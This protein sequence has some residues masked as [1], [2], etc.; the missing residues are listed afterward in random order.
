MTMRTPPIPVPTHDRTAAGVITNTA[1][2]GTPVLGNGQWYQLAQ[3]VNWLLGHGGALAW[4]PRQ[5]QITAGN[6]VTLR[7]F[8]WPRLGNRARL[9]TL[10]MQ[11]RSASGRLETPTY[12]GAAGLPWSCNS[13]SATAVVNIVEL[14]DAAPDHEGEEITAN[15]HVNINSPSI[16]QLHSV[17]C[18]ELPI[19]R[20]R[21]QNGLPYGMRQRSC[22]K[23][24][25][26]FA[27]GGAG[28]TDAGNRSVTGVAQSEA[29]MREGAGAAR[30]KLFDW[31][32]ED[33]YVTTSA[34][35]VNMFH[36]NPSMQARA[37]FGETTRTVQVAVL[38]KVSTGGNCVV[39]LTSAA[40]SDWVET[41]FT[42]DVPTW[43]E[44]SFDIGAENPE[45]A[46]WLRSGD[47]EVEIEAISASGTLTVYAIVVGESG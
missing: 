27:F 12:P 17:T 39:R 15:V 6:E 36:V 16:T 3:N 26:I 13:G 35:W 9:W 2:I 47:H 24:H 4:W 5:G 29:A 28:A 34:S 40:T 46:A 7:S 10:C 19:T 11:A 43:V 41:P 25:P 33:G 1:R 45:A 21:G 18:A 31:S 23:G 20:L 14:L 30:R 22:L 37:P 32:T 8:C 42:A 44:G 38:A